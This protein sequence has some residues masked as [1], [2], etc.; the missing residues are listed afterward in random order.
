MARLALLICAAVCMVG[1]SACFKKEKVHKTADT[2][3]DEDGLCRHN[4]GYR[5]AGYAAGRLRGQH[6]GDRR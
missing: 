4:A 5:G 2:E 3:D 1:L 6:E